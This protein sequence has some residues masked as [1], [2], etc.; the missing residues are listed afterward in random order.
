MRR[1]G[2][3]GESRG[4]AR[5]DRGGLPAARH[6]PDQEP[7]RD[8]Q[9]GGERRLAEARAGSVQ[10][11]PP[12]HRRHHRRRHL[13]H[14]RHR[15][16]RRRRS[17]GCRP[18]A[19]DLLRHH[20][21]RL[22]L[23][24]PLLRRVRL[25]GADLRLGLHLFLRHPGRA[26]RLDHRLGPH[27]RVRRRQRRRG[28]QLGQLLPLAPRGLR[29]PRAALAGDRLPHRRS[30][31]R[32]RGERASHL[33]RADR[34]QPPRLPHRRRHHHR[35]GV[36][37]P[38]VGGLQRHHG[39]DQ[40][41]RPPLL[42][43]RRLLLRLAAH[44]GGELGALPAQRLARHLRRRGDRLLRLHRLRRRLDRRRGDQEPVARP[45]DRHHR[46]ARHL[47]HLLHR[48]WRRSSPA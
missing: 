44:H 21:D 45:A 32:H 11:H 47:H 20:G 37:H 26:G 1:N 13:C 23:H 9:D 36:G 22:R 48:R 19:D 3:P 6:L 30:T 7:R 39:G 12:R 5:D 28:D 4:S 40:D 41:P 43:R 38:R 17:P 27:H 29:H 8:P 24:R 2:P 46:L 16:G 34:L 15:R 31:P 42:H 25:D 18:V 10:R 33:R 35:P 14:H